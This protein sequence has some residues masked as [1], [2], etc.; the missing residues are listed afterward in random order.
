MTL[1]QLYSS[2]TLRSYDYIRYSSDDGRPEGC[3]M[4]SPF[5]MGLNGLISR[6]VS[7][8]VKQFKLTGEWKEHD[9]SECAQVGRVP[10]A[11]MML[12]T[13]VR[14]AIA[15]MGAL[16]E[17]KWLGNEHQDATTVW[18]GLAKSPLSKLTVRFPTI[19][20]ARPIA[21]VPPIP[22]LVSLKIYD[23]DPLC[24]VDDISLLLQGS[25]KLRDLKLI[26]SPRM[27]EMR[28]PSININSIFGRIATARS[29]L[30]LR[31][32]AI[33]NL[34]MFDDGTCD[35]VV[36]PC[37]LE[38]VTFINSFGGHGD[39]PGS[40]F[41]DGIKRVK[42]GHALPCMRSFRTDKISKEHCHFFS[43]FNGLQKFYI[44][45]STATQQQS[46]TPMPASPA[47]SPLPPGASL[48]SLKSPYLDALTRYHGNT[49]T[50]LLLLPTWRL[51]APEI[52]P[53]IR[54]CPHLQQLAL[55][56]DHLDFTNV[57]VLVLSLPR[58]QALRI[59]DHPD[60]GGLFRKKVREMDEMGLVAEQ[61]QR[62]VTE[63]GTGGTSGGP[64]V[65]WIGLANLVFE[66]GR[67]ERQEELEGEQRKRKVW[68]RGLRDVEG[69]DIWKMDSLEAKDSTYNY[70]HFNAPRIAD[71]FEEFTRAPHLPHEPIHVPQHLQPP[72]PEDE[73]D[74]VP[75]QHAAFGITRAT[76]G[77]REPQWKDLGLEA[78]MKRGPGTKEMEKGLR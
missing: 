61:I 34:F 45:S 9:L 52:A 12:N 68:R 75:D 50:H 4:A 11:S 42:E 63:M 78:L 58:L 23:I 7:G 29:P 41:V 54:A 8:Y 24:Y 62:V 10:D 26:W 19:R 3:G 30:K 49:L 22:N 1:P 5:T 67:M 64:L 71:L 43:T 33:K 2:V 73:D 13:L 40:A 46:C 38:K 25:K 6:N 17:F 65:R 44:V 70:I 53:L 60:D 55:G 47:S 69:V 18:Q 21:I 37:Y 16:Q 15:R 77:K 36:D 14:A 48:S 56:I 32:L 57:K 28:E 20:Q 74:V 72:N 35:N 39:S 59:L 27:R 66:V 51:S 76:Q 31:S